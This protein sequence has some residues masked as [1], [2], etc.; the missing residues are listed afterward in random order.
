[1]KRTTVL[2][3]QN[4]EVLFINKALGTDDGHCALK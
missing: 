1:M 3:W 4:A 2:R